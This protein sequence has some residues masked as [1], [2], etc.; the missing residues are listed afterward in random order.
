MDSGQQ[1]CSDRWIE[2]Q[3]DKLLNIWIDGW[4]ES[5]MDGKDIWLEFY[6]NEFSHLQERREREMNLGQETGCERW[7][8]G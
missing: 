2:K 6:R 4:N 5:Q 1:S 7:I 8:D 3:I